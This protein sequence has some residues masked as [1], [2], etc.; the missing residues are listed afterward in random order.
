MKWDSKGSR[1]LLIRILISFKHAFNGLFYTIKSERNMQI[2]VL[3]AITVIILGFV[4]NIK[5]YEWFTIII[6]IGMMFILE[7]INTSIEHIVDLLSPSYNIHAKI[8]K[9]TAAATVLVFAIIS[10]II[11]VIIFLPPILELFNIEI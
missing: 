5:V 6:L 11:G 8:A 10:V 4:F 1:F 3:A 2:H 9:D 7:T